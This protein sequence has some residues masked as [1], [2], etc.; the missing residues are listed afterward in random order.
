VNI[1]E[2]ELYFQAKGYEII[3]KC[4]E[5]TIQQKKELFGNASYI[6]GPIS[7]AFFNCIWCPSDVKILGLIN[8][9]I[10]FDNLLQN[11]LSEE[12]EIYHLAGKEV[13]YQFYHSD[14]YIG[15]EEVMQYSVKLGFTS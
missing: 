11:L 14:F 15:L 9:E 8:Y 7:S 2:I 12:S 13:N 5:L 3:D 10:A 1:Q 4:H 6:V